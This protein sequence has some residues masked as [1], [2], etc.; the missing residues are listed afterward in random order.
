MSD[1]KK[2]FTYVEVDDSTPVQ[3]LK[4]S[5]QLRVLLKRITEDPASEL[6]SEEVFT[7]EYLTLKADFTEMLLK[8]AAPL[9]AGKNKSVVIS[10]DSKYNYVMDEVLKSPTISRFY[11]V[12]VAKPKIEYDVPCNS[13]VKL[14]IKDV[15]PVR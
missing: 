2:L 1:R 10:V 11:E 3:K 4:F 9:R 13:L 7:T 12:S 8:A 5:D 6:K 14:Q 15:T